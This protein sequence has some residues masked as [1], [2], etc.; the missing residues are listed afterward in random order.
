[1]NWCLLS[2]KFYKKYPQNLKYNVKKGVYF[3]HS[4]GCYSIQLDHVY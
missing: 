3:S 1:M 2:N 4:F